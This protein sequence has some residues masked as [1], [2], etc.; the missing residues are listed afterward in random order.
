MPSKQKNNLR[1]SKIVFIAHPISGDIQGNLAKV[2]EIGREINL[3]EDV[4]PFAP[5]YFD[6]NC[7]RDDIPEE[8]ERGIKNSSQLLRFADEL[9][10]YGDRISQGMKKEIDIAHRLGITVK[11]MTRQTKYQYGQIVGVQEELF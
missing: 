5:Y 7:L 2:R 9:R 1:Y 6:C 10:L 3:K 11:P 4:I 8:R